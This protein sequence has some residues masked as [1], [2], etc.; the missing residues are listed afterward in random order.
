MP[1]WC[2]GQSPEGTTPVGLSRHPSV[3]GSVTGSALGGREAPPF[4]AAELPAMQ[5]PPSMQT[6]PPSRSS[7]AG[8]DSGQQS[9]LGSPNGEQPLHTGSRA[10]GHSLSRQ[11]AAVQEARG[12]EQ[13]EYQGSSQGNE[14]GAESSEWGEREQPAEPALS[15]GLAAPSFSQGLAG[16]SL[17]AGLVIRPLSDTS[18]SPQG[19]SSSEPTT[20]Q[21]LHNLHIC[22]HTTSTSPNHTGGNAPGKGQR[23]DTTHYSDR[24]PT[25]L[26]LF[27]GHQGGASPIQV[28]H[29]SSPVQAERAR[30]GLPALILPP[31][32][33][34]PR[35]GGS[36]ACHSGYTSPS[37]YS[38]PGQFRPHGWHGARSPVGAQAVALQRALA[39]SCNLFGSDDED[40]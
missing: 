15:N 4:S 10:H 31:Q 30:F 13:S 3:T 40:E 18:S 14:D 2:A 24:R 32:S 35:G 37:M 33:P 7:M 26:R 25:P 27:L 9:S 19:G 34:A 28:L 38:S 39:E 6:P 36:P 23:A 5:T 22:V 12:E 20:P 21:P 16:H 17:A 11:L 1:C 8:T 29:N